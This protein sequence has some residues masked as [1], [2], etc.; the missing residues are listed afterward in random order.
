MLNWRTDPLL[1]DPQPVPWPQWVTANQLIAHK[2]STGVFPLFLQRYQLNG[3]GI[4]VRK[5]DFVKT[6]PRDR[7]LTRFPYLGMTPLLQESVEQNVH[8][9]SLGVS[10]YFRGA[11]RFSPLEGRKKIERYL[12]QGR[13]PLP[14]FRVFAHLQPDENDFLIEHFTA[15][16]LESF[17]HEPFHFPLEVTEPL[18]YF[19]GA[20]AG[21]GTLNPHQIRIVDGHKD[22]MTRLHVLAIKLTGTNPELRPEAGGNAWLLILKSKWGARLVHFLTSQPFGRKYNSLQLPKIFQVLSNREKVEERYYQGLYDTDGRC[23]K[24]SSEVEVKSKAR[25]LIEDLERFLTTRQIPWRK[26]MPK[27]GL[28]SISVACRGIRQF[29]LT[30]GFLSPAKQQA[31]IKLLSR[32]PSFL[33]FIGPQTA[34]LTATGHFNFHLLPNLLVVDGYEVWQERRQESCQG[35]R[36]IPVIPVKAQKKWAR[37]GRVPFRVLEQTL[38]QRG[39]NVYE[40]LAKRQLR[41]V[42]PYGKYPIKLPSRP[43]TPHLLDTIAYLTPAPAQHTVIVTTGTFRSTPKR[44]AKEVVHRAATLFEIA[45]ESFQCFDGRSFR[46]VNR[47]LCDYLQTF[48]RYAKPW[49]A[50]SPKEVEQAIAKWENIL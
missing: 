29:A 28:Q 45:P 3:Y 42:Y 43:E 17:R 37:S 20:C 40:A 2:S 34:T 36:L 24:Q 27:T 5:S 10:H 11:E 46:I 9:L 47:L 14:F 32:G 35:P 38:R 41:Y 7:L 44:R 21:D 15:A 31:L 19:L 6:T 18:A 23:H 16:N 4:M 22:Y 1:M 25:Q 12:T 49:Q 48:F 8:R 13:L 30:V 39:L 50:L 33:D 26:S